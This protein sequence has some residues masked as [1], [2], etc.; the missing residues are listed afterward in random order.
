MRR[1]MQ[2]LQTK[3]IRTFLHRLKVRRMRLASMPLKAEIAVT[4][5]PVPFAQRLD[6]P[7]HYRPIEAGE[8]WGTAW[9]SAWLH[10]TGQVPPEWAGEDV[11]LCFNVNGEALVFDADGC[12]A[13]GL[14]HASVFDDGQGKDIYRLFE[15]CKGGEN[16]DLWI[17]AAANGLFGI[18]RNPH[19]DRWSPKR[20]GT[21]SGH[22]K[23][24]DLCLFDTDLWHLYLDLDVLFNLE[25]SLPE[26]TPRRTRLLTGICAAID[27]YADNRNNATPARAALAPL[28][29]TPVNPADLT[30]TAVG[31]AHID[32]GWLW[33]VRETIRKSARTFA[34]QLSLMDR[35]PDFIFGAS[36]PQHYA[37]I[38]AHYPA[39]FE[40]IRARIAEGRW[41]CQGAMWVEADCNIT[42]G[43]SLVRQMLHGKNFFM[44]E[45]GVNVRNLWIPD[46]FGYSAAIPQI[47]K[48]AGVDFFLTQ[49]L[50]WSLHNTFPHSTFKWRG[51]DGS[52]I[53]THFPPENTYNSFLMPN[54]MRQAQ[55]RF[56]ENNRCDEF[57]SLFGLGDGGG[58]PREDH[59][60]RGLRQQ[61][62]NGTPAIR[63][64][65]AEAFFDRLARNADELETWVGELYLELHRG[66]LTTQAATKRGNRKLEL[67]LRETEALCACL[68]A[69]RYPRAELDRIWKKLL[70]NQFHDIL[71]GSSIQTVYATALQD[72]AECMDACD[73]L[74]T[75]ATTHLF[76][77]D[78]LALTL[79]NSLSIDYTAPITLP[80]S[81][82]GHQVLDAGGAPLPCQATGNGP[83][84]RI[85]LPPLSF[86]TLRRGAAA[87]APPPTAHP[88]VPVLENALVR[89]EFT[90]DGAIA[91]ILDKQNGRER[92]PDKA[93]ANVFSLYVDRPH[94]WDAWEVDL[95]YE[96]QWLENA[97]GI[98]WA[99][100]ASGAVQT[101]LRFSLAI[102]DST[103]EQSITLP[104]DSPCLRF[105]TRVDWQ[106]LHKMLRVAF[107]TRAM[108]TE[109][110]CEIQ[111]GFVKRPTHRNTSWDMAKFEVAAYRYVD[112]SDRDGGLALLNDCKYG[113][114]V[115]EHVVD[116]NL[117]RSPTEPDPDADVGTHTFSYAL[118]PR[119][120]AFEPAEV[121]P[122][123]AMLNQPPVI[124]EGR[125]HTGTLLPCALSSDGLS[126]EVLKRGEKQ[127]CWVVRLVETHGRISCGTLH[128]TVAAAAWVDTDL[129]E[130][131]DGARR[132]ADAPLAV[133]LKP[134]EIRTLKL[135]PADS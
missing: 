44:D 127:D 48:L 71:P 40:K 88:P 2:V 28:F 99:P 17:E 89:Y 124:I 34:S 41:E 49:K 126:L 42:S 73:A 33:P 95:Y 26:H 114:K 7:C 109:A 47:M 94:S 8:V 112:L 134:F 122:P 36:Q 13:Y 4:D 130:W 43:E 9:Q 1:E 120:D 65:T 93:E 23:Y 107:P 62:L 12:P 39:L 78:E 57:I 29:Q 101:G 110:T 74:M 59:V 92:L 98:A 111:Y 21:Y 131:N 6:E 24:I 79:F 113:F 53:I 103:I 82:S 3:R 133:E 18:N 25:Q 32:T 80:A 54:S 45:F 50:S 118:L 19:G 27:V 90:P 16:V 69:D 61:A 81:W 56:A 83:V 116:M 10:V 91:R 76:P 22:V 86:T 100:L 30:V 55:D 67:K 63:F 104:A 66:T 58:G 102:G 52:E 85:T 72:Y 108:T 87:P 135:L 97:R 14:T 51:I 96:N 117:L 64:G 115:H 84:V 132:P 77:A 31:H 37:F 105:D 15:P 38:K 46:V 128:A 123:A 35:Y 70:I 121:I 20:H 129:M 5:D 68:P 11:A 125:A 119:S 60:E 106:E 75:Q